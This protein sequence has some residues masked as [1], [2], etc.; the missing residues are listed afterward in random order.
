M[1]IHFCCSRQ[2]PTLSLSGIPGMCAHSVASVVFD[3]EMLWT[4]A[5]QAPLSIGFSGQEYWSGLPCSSPGDLSDSGIE[6]VSLMS[7]CIGRWV[8][9]FFFYHECHLGSNRRQTINM[10]QK[11]AGGCHLKCLCKPWKN[12]PPVME[13]RPADHA[14]KSE[15]P[16]LSLTPSLQHLVMR[17]V[18]VKSRP[19]GLR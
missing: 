13:S 8:F 3:S 7:S 15:W 9:F 1:H 18:D 11:P 2:P 5:R 14:T 19:D 10:K 16:K 6:P 4:A 17:S 12:I